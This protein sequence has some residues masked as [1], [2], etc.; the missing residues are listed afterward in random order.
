VYYSDYSEL[1]NSNPLA[2]IRI[3]III[4]AFA[5]LIGLSV[6]TNIRAE[7]SATLRGTTNY[8]W[9]GFTK[10]A[11]KPA[12]Q[13]N[14][15][16]EHAT[17]F[18]LGTS[19]STVNFGD[20][21]FSDRSNVEITPY[22]GWSFSATDDWR[23]DLQFQRY[24]YD[25]KIFNNQSDYNELYA[26]AHYQDLFTARVSFSPNYYNRDHPA[27]DFGITGRFP[28]TETVNLSSGIGYSLA[29][30]VL[31]YDYLYWNAG[32]S[33]HHRYGALDLR[34]TQ[35]AFFN[36]KEVPDRDRWLFE[37]ERLGPTIVF[38]ISF[39]F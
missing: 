39:G 29:R 6:A 31:E 19:A 21:G 7:F 37:P 22:L 34:Y 15:D 16:Y 32:I 3:K 27:A 33:W 5:F 4:L 28:L 36:E 1:Q 38:T 26:F 10:S 13:A 11:N 23:V 30:D 35:S 17:G 25:G 20:R 14:I 18:F 24:I 9:R 8:V 2:I 12:V